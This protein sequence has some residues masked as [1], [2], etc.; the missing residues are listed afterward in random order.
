MKEFKI[1]MTFQNSTVCSEMCEVPRMSPFHSVGASAHQEQWPLGTR[2]NT[3]QEY[4][5]EEWRDPD[6]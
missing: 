4:L 1:K 3:H 6:P 2:L 5:P